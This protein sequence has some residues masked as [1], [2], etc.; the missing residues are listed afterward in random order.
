[1]GRLY[2]APNLSRFRFGFIWLDTAPNECGHLD[3]DRLNGEGAIFA[4]PLFYDYR[5]H[6]FALLD[7]ILFLCVVI[8]RR[9]RGLEVPDM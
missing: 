6:I 9:I 2:F 5:Q 4:F 8:L 3:G 7:V 1:M